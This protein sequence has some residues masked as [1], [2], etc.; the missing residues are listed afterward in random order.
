MIT[1]DNTEWRDVILDGI[2]TDYL[3]NAKGQVYSKISNKILKASKCNTGYLSIGIHYLGKCYKSVKIHRLVAETFIPNPDPEN[4]TQVNHKDGNKTNNCVEN[5]EWVT[6]KENSDHAWATG[7]TDNSKY[8]E[9]LILKIIDLLLK[10]YTPSDISKRLKVPVTL[11]AD[12]K[13]HKIWKRFTEGIEFPD[14]PFSHNLYDEF[15]D[16]PTGYIKYL[17]TNGYTNNQIYNDT[18]LERSLILHKT[19][20][21]I[22]KSMISNSYP[23]IKN[24][25]SN[26]KLSDSEKT[27]LIKDVKSNR[28]KLKYARDISNKE[29]FNENRE[30]YDLNF[31]LES[32]D[33]E[34]VVIFKYDD[35]K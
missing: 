2:K 23:T 32:N 3:V 8:P 22:R 26:K 6:H 15:E 10:G 17:I 33:I 27:K 12:I 25:K 31:V 28:K 5:L 1:S 9:S 34:E 21:K 29:W 13:R 14:Y 7:L 18:G 35:M 4:K 11:P 19:L 24:I 16:I 20:S 30:Y